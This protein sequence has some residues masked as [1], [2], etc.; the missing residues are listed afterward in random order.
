M[1]LHVTLP[2]LVAICGKKHEPV[3]SEPVHV[4]TSLLGAVKSQLKQQLH[5]IGSSL[6]ELEKFLSVKLNEMT[7]WTRLLN[8]SSLPPISPLLPDPILEKEFRSLSEIR[9]RVSEE[10]RSITSQSLVLLAMI[11]RARGLCLSASSTEIPY[12]D[13]ISETIEMESPVGDTAPAME[14]VNLRDL[15]TLLGNEIVTWICQTILH[16]CDAEPFLHLPLSDFY[17]GFMIGNESLYR[18]AVTA[19]H[20]SN[21]RY[22]SFPPSLSPPPPLTP[23]AAPFSS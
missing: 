6:S 16:L 2:L 4:T 11:E 12:T 14:T 20:S 22:R 3:G 9:Q 8:T 1:L 13:L 7:K 10:L 21:I 17:C 23:S 18:L 19:T 15:V 5:Q